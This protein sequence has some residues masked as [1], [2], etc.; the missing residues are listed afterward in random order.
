MGS[1]TTPDRRHDQRIGWYAADAAVTA[2]FVWITVTSL[3]SDAYVDE[4][5]PIE[6]A[7]WVLALSPTLLLMFRRIAPVTAL[8]SATVLYMAA[9]ASQGDSNAP[10]A[11]PL[12]TYSV[13]YT[14]PPSASGPIVAAVAVALSTTVLYGPGGRDVL[15]IVVWCA[16]VGI[17]WLVAYS[18]RRNQLSAA[19]SADEAAEARRT[20]AQLT[21]EAVADERARIALE[22][23]DAVGHTVN[24]MLLQAGA[25]RLTGDRDRALDAL[26]QI[27][28]LGRE[29]LTD[30]DHMLSLMDDTD[31]P[32]RRPAH[33]IDDIKRLV[34]DM[35]AA[36]VDVDLRVDCQCQVGRTVG[37]AAYRVV[38]EALTNAIKHAG[39]AHIDVTIEC[40]ERRLDITV[41]DDGR[42]GPVLDGRGIAGM[43]ERIAV[44]GGRLTAGP[45]ADGGFR[46]DAHIPLVDPRPELGDTG[47]AVER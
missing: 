13:G 41:E 45:G 25:A 35:R 46:I 16:L 27:E 31:G 23:H 5:G 30:L 32:D 18:V 21:A 10:L 29:A 34:A 26:S 2:L 40:R 1:W 11:I 24:V 8:L 39:P 43:T 7:G 38:Q 37:A 4:Y 47:T 28:E 14:R 9:S 15:V 19:A 6:G 12:F 3:R 44:L 22:L 42:G 17:G 36:G 33:S 20:S